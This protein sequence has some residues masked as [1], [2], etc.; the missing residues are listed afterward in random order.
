ML[1]SRFQNESGSERKQLDSF[2]P[3]DLPSSGP[4]FVTQAGAQTEM[5]LDDII[6]LFSSSFEKPPSRTTA[7]IA[8]LCSLQELEVAQISFAD[9]FIFIYL[10]MGLL[11]FYV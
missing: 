9:F 6:I 5:T 1:A 7:D 10:Y 8:Q 11:F 2:C 3:D 4:A